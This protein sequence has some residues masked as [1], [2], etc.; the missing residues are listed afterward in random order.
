MTCY[1]A[2]A[3]GAKLG[4]PD[5]L[6]SIHKVEAVVECKGENSGDLHGRVRES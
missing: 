3:R 1:S 6:V 5:E 2:N 4:R